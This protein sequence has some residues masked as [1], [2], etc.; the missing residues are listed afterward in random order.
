MRKWLKKALAMLACA[1]MGVT[2]TISM[3]SCD[4]NTAVD[5][6]K[7]W[8]DKVVTFLGL[9]SKEETS[10]DSS[11]SSEHEHSYTESNVV[12]ATCTTEGSRTL[13]CTCGSEITE[14]IEKLAHTFTKEDTAEKYLASA[15]T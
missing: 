4:F 3:A 12:E 8:K 7:S 9:G 13:I 10:E 5:Q 14:V 2:T 1:V 15:A 11:I 6:V